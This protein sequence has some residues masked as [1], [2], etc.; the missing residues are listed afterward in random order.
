MDPNNGK[1]PMTVE[2]KR[3]Y[4]ISSLPGAW[5]HFLVGALGSSV[6]IFERDPQ[7]SFTQ[8]FKTFGLKTAEV[9]QSKS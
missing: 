3:N 2:G 7:S 5:A 1:I 6:D 9:L 8:N 4:L